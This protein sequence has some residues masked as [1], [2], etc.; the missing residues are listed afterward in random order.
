MKYANT[1][2]K[3]NTMTIKQRNTDATDL[4]AQNSVIVL[5]KITRTYTTT[6]KN[7]MTL[8]RANTMTIFLWVD[9]Y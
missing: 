6:L 2:S 4:V 9:R 1:S 8:T 7:T 5:E 3:Q